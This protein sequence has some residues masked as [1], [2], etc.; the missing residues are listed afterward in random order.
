[1]TGLYHADT[2]LECE[3]KVELSPSKKVD[4]ICFDRRPFKMKSAFSC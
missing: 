3:F 2:D 4:W 1:M